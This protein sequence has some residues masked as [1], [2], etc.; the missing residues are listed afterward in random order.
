MSN[1]EWIEPH[2]FVGSSHYWVYGPIVYICPNNRH[3]DPRIR[4]QYAK[5]TQ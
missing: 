2:T 3:G 5:Q 1:E 4:V